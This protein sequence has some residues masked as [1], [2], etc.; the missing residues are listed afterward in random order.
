MADNEKAEIGDIV[1]I[2]GYGNDLF[3]IISVHQTYYRDRES[4]YE[5]VEYETFNLVDRRNY[6]AEDLDI[7]IVSRKE[8]QAPKTTLEKE[9]AAKSG[10]GNKTVD[11]LLD[12]LRDVITLIELFG[13]SE[14]YEERKTKIKRQLSDKAKGKESI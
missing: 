12:E 2:D 8:D 7:T 10:A 4:E 14:E 6:F 5:V 9:R 1:R 11:E 3:E 13:R